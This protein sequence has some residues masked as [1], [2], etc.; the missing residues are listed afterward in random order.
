MKNE[1]FEEKLAYAKEVLDRLMKPDIT[2]EDSVKLYQQGLENLKE[3]N[4]LI[5]E[6]KAKITI[7]ERSY[8]GEERT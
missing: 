8:Q 7:I 2:L 1:S 6:A 5:E 4:R 3:A